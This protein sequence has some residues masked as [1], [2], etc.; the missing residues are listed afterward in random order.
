[1][2]LSTPPEP[3]DADLKDPFLAA[4]GER[5]RALRARRGLT[6]K[7][8]AKAAEVSER[9]LANVEMG[10]GNASV[11]F[12]RQLALALNCSLAELVG[13]E[14]ASSPEWL[15]IRELLRGRSDADLVQARGALAAMFGAPA[16][17]AARRQRIALIGLRGAGKSTLGRGLAESWNLPFVEL[18]RSIEALAGCTLSEI[19]SL[20]GPA[21]Y[22]R[23]EKRAMEETIQ[24]FPRAVIATPGGIVSDPATFNLL[25]AHCYTVWVRATPEEHM[26]RVLAQGDTRPMAGHAGNVEAMNDLRRILESRAAFYSKADTVFDTSEKAPGAALAALREQLRDVIGA[27]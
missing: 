7:G 24:R 26:G 16:S 2:D 23:Y 19:H 8:L 6:R 5:T 3:V 15:M 11:Q 14:T 18:N 25:L 22:R 13:D 1:M 27:T 20:Y 21:A 10:V 4:L 17:P 12:L 9:H